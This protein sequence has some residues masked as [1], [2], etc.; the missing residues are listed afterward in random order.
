MRIK[1]AYRYELGPNNCQKT[2]LTQHAGTARFAYNWGLEQRNKQYQEKKGKEKY[3]NAIKQHKTLNKLKKN[4]FPWMYQVS[5]CAP[6]EALRDLQQAFQNFFDGLKGKRSPVGF[7]KF[8]KKGKNDS[9]RLTGTIKVIGRKIRL[10]ILGRIR[11]KEK[12]ETYFQGR[13]LSATISKRADR[14]FV[15]IKVEEEVI[16]PTNEGEAVGV[17]LGIKNL[18]VTSTGNV[19]QNPKVLT[20]RLRKL[21]RLSRNFSRKEK[22]SKNMEKARLRL[23]RFHLKV[24]NIRRDCLHKLTTTLAKN[25]SQ[26]VVEDLNVSGMMK[27]KKLA[28]AISDV[29]FYEFRR[30]LEYKTKCYGSELVVAPRFYPSSKRCSKCGLVK[31]ELSLSER[32]FVC[33]VCGLVL[34]RDLNAAL[35]LLA[36]SCTDTLNACWRRE[37]H[38]TKQVLS[39]EARTEHHKGHIS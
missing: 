7:P 22:G 17:D 37:V 18:A 11:I 35:N 21:K 5:K 29:G 8:K 39:N 33:E 32:T 6:Q 4:Q 27:N 25:H 1:R 23:A 36:V 12:R 24:S 13:I 15:S 2:H 3:T 16:I 34:D 31:G 20:T 30:Q 9:F 26:V 38:A 28:R 10:P 14:W 19:Y